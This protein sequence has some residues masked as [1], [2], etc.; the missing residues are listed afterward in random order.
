MKNKEKYKEELIDSLKRGNSL[1]EFVRQHDVFRTTGRQWD[2]YCNSTNCYTCITILNLWLD[3]EYEES[4]MDW[5][6]V[7]IDT[8]VR[9]RNSK[10]R[11]LNVAIFQGH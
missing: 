4:E 7:P 2:N 1:C 5:Y 6:Y 11:K 3:E 9:V 8:L 10:K